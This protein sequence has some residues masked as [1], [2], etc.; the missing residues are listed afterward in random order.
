VRRALVVAA[1]LLCVRAATAEEA[2]GH[3]VVYPLLPT[4]KLSAS[5]DDD[6]R[7]QA[8]IDILTSLSADWQ[9][10]VAPSASVAA[11]GGVADL[12]RVD[13]GKTSGP[14]RWSAGISLSFVGWSRDPYAGLSREQAQRDRAWAAC[15]AH[16]AETQSA[17]DDGTTFCKDFGAQ[18]SWPASVDPSQLCKA[19]QEALHDVAGPVYPP[20][21]AHPSYVLAAGGAVSG[22]TF[23]YFAAATSMALSP[24]SQSRTGGT[25]ALSFTLVRQ[26]F[27][28]DGVTFELAAVYETRWRGSGTPVRICVPAGWLLGNPAQSCEDGVLGAPTE[29]HRLFVAAE[30]GYVDIHTDPRDHNRPKSVWRFAAGPIVRWTSNGGRLDVGAQLPVY[31]NLVAAGGGGEVYKGIVRLTPTIVAVREGDTWRPLIALTL[32]LIGDRFLF[33]RGLDWR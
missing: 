29:A 16:C 4:L 6:A 17:D 33:P 11:P 28:R 2:R 22:A 32:D 3:G 23:D 24:K 15:R 13:D 26:L 12:F 5:T 14:K 27:R 25:A 31:L 21:G 30:A 1:T 7:V 19:G 8:S 18:Q 20:F 9:L 10:E